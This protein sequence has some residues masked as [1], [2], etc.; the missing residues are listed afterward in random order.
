MAQPEFLSLAV[1][2]NTNEIKH[3]REVHCICAENQ[4]A[5]TGAFLTSAYE[6]DEVSTINAVD[7][8]PGEVY[9]LLEAWKSSDIATMS[10]P[11]RMDLDAVTQP[12]SVDIFEP[13]RRVPVAAPPKRFYRTFWR[14]ASRRI[15]AL[16]ERTND[17]VD[18]TF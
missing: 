7:F 14:S 10:P 4:S 11:D 1:K 9:A 2:S 3:T 8:I 18:T 6:G 13:V 12:F 15:L 17:V 16:S 5:F